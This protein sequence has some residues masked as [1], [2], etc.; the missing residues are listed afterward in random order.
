MNGRRAGREGREH[1]ARVEL[2]LLARLRQHG[3]GGLVQRRGAAPRQ[4]LHL[5]LEAAGGA[6]AGDGGRVEGEREGAGEPH[7]LR[8]HAATISEARC[9]G[10]R[11]SQGFRMANSTAE[12]DCAA[13]VRKLRP[14]DRA[15]DLD[16]GLVL[17]HVADLLGHR[18]GALQRGAVR[19][20]D[21][22]EEVA[23][24]LD[25]QEG[26]WAC[27]PTGDRCRT[28]PARSPPAGPAEADE[29]AHEARVA[30][31]QRVEARVEPAEQHE[32]LSV[33]VA[34][35]GGAERGAQRQRVEGRDADRDRHREGELVVEP[36]GDAR[37]E[38]DGHE[39]RHQHRGG[40]DDGARHLAHGAARGLQRRRGP[41][42]AGARRSRPPRWRR[43]PRGRWPAPCRAGSAC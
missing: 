24:V 32:G 15:D 39:H 21:H 9:A 25:R 29:A 5:E 14:A 2:G 11:S 20:L 43:R 1:L 16:A 27:A 6:E 41:S 33:P 17:Q 8:A 7:Q 37:D 34:Q 31:R 23:L 19:P 18:V 38:G 30:V 28:A 12:F 4:V 26:R 42:R 3:L 13:L 40:G 35:E 22:D 36:P 10:G